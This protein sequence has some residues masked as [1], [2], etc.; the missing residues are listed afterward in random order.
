MCVVI[1]SIKLYAMKP[2]LLK[3]NWQSMEQRMTGVVLTVS[4]NVMN[5]MLLYAAPP[6][7]KSNP[8]PMRT[9]LT[10]MDVLCVNVVRD[11]SMMNV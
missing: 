7:R 5:T 8:S 6:V 4:V 11:M 9:L 3:T 1:R 2:A 10:T